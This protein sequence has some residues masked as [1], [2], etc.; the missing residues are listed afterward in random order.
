MKKLLLIPLMFTLSTTTFADS[1]EHL[2]PREQVC[3]SNRE[4]MRDVIDDRRN[5]ISQEQVQLGILNAYNTYKHTELAVKTLATLN[6]LADSV[7]MLPQE[8]IDDLKKSEKF[9]Q[10][11]FI[12]CW[13]AKQDPPYES[14]N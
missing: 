13:L 2:R 12:L 8:I 5:D 4:F 14:L 11:A 3:I 7:F 6:N 9:L 10:D 1:L